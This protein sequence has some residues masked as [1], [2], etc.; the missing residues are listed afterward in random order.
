M[1]KYYIP[2]TILNLGNILSTDSISPAIFYEKR[3][4]GN[5]HWYKIEENKLDNALLLYSTPFIFTRS[6]GEKEDRAM[7]IQVMVEEEFPEMEKGVFI[8]NHTI[9]FD[10]NTYFI[11]FSEEDREVAIS[12]CQ[13]G[14]TSKLLRLYQQKRMIV[15]NNYPK[16]SSLPQCKEIPLNED[17]ISK[18]FRINKIKGFLYGYYIGAYL[19]IPPQRIGALRVCHEIYARL[20][21]LYSANK[22]KRSWTNDSDNI[23]M[24]VSEFRN[25]EEERANKEKVHLEPMSKEIIVDDLQITEISNNYIRED[26][27][28]ILLKDWINKVLM[29]NWKRNVNSVKKD[30]LDEITDETKMFLLETWDTSYQRAFLNDLRHHIAGE[31]FQ[32]KLKND[33]YSSLAVFILKGDDWEDMM[34]LMRKHEIYDYRIALGLY[35]AFWGFGSLLHNFTDNLLQQDKEYVKRVYEDFYRLIFGRPIPIIK[36]EDASNNKSLRDVVLSVW[37]QTTESQKDPSKYYMG[38]IETLEEMERKSLSDV[39]IFIQRLKNKK[40]WKKG[41]RIKEFESLL[42]GDLFNNE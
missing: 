10:W 33:L 41:K 28:K 23:L 29:K 2:T 16:L 20:S 18:D 35:G 22:I 36:E 30:L 11:F 19:S 42:M 17:N 38:I 1:M 9:Y 6:K 26:L 3:N 21:S 5:P 25:K 13:I 7:L 40:Y 27:E 12:L 32:H 34:E 39:N 8:C 14:D 31:P 24:I 4:F 15:K 37:K